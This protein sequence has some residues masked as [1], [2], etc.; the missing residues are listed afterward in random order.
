MS[1]FNIG[2]LIQH[3]FV[4]E[5][6]L[7]DQVLSH[8]FFLCFIRIKMNK[9]PPMT[10]VITPTGNPEGVATLATQSDAMSNRAPTARTPP[11]RR[12]CSPSSR[13]CSPTY[14]SSRPSPRPGV[15][16]G[17]LQPVKVPAEPGVPEH[18]LDQS[19]VPHRH[20]HVRIERW[21]PGAYLLFSLP[22]KN[23]P[24]PAEHAGRRPQP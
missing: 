23:S 24:V 1:Y 7:E 15:A 10:G 14:P 22:L 6:K 20:R 3:P 11:W 18:S 21:H 8:E 19:L 5:L 17:P 9:G 16:L 4:I 13:S 12:D 2:V